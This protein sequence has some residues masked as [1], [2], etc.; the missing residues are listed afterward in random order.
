MKLYFIA[1]VLPPQLRDEINVFKEEMKEKY[2][3]KHALKIPAHITMQPPF[4]FSEG[5]E[6]GLISAL[7]DFAGQQE[8][9]EVELNGFGSFPPR[10]IYVRVTDHQPIIRLHNSLQQVTKDFVKQDKGRVESPI[11]PHVTIASRD[12]TKSAFKESWPQFK[13]R[14]YEARFSVSNLVLLKHN[15]QHWELY[16][17]LAFKNDK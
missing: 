11:H 4:K 13:T 1:I 14:S 17:D 6:E 15:G 10:V 3:A 9:F 8:N 2:G 12:L 7:E 16:K 5:E